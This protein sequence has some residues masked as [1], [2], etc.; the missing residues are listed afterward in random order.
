MKKKIPLFLSLYL[1]IGAIN[2]EPSSTYILGLGDPTLSVTHPTIEYMFQPSSEFHRF[3]NY[4][5]RDTGGRSGVVNTTIFIEPTDW[6]NQS[7][8]TTPDAARPTS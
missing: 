3:G 8:V 4:F 1:L 7:V 2:E 6:E 5:I